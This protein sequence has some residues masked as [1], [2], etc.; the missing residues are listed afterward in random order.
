[1]A[2]GRHSD[3]EKD[4]NSETTLDPKYVL[5]ILAAIQKVKGQKQRPSEDRI[6]HVLETSYGLSTSIISEQLELCVKHG[7]VLKVTFKGLSSYKNPMQ[8]SQNIRGSIEKPVDFQSYASEALEQSGE[9]GCTIQAVEKYI[10]E[11]YSDVIGT[12]TDV[13]THV[14]TVLKK[15]L[16]NGILLKEGRNYR[17]ASLTKV[18]QVVHVH[19]VYYSIQKI[20]SSK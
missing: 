8:A 5:W 17:L 10:Q 3:K 20:K 13:H 9:E 7:K 1:M 16:M 19:Y 15:G 11:Q 12:R 4:K 2:R 6:S 18:R 14:K